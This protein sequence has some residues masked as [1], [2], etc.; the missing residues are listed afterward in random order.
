M[1]KNPFFENYF[2]AI[3]KQSNIFSREEYEEHCRMFEINYG[4]FIPEN[5][6]CKILD[7]GC[8][9]GHFLY[10][11]QKKGYKN[12][13]GIDISEQQSEYCKKNVTE[14]VE[15]VDTFLYLEGKDNSY[16]VITAND[17]I[18]H[19]SKD[20]V[21]SFLSLI[22]KAL[23]PG[24]VCIMKTPNLGNPFTLFLR[25]KDFTH[26]TG[27][28]ETSFYQ[29]FWTSGF[30]DIDILPLRQRGILNN[31]F[32]SVFQ[33]ILR[34]LFWYQGFTAPKILSPLIIGVVKK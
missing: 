7:I 33:F 28:T 4:R 17:L 2:D 20:N 10:F 31:L 18:E 21:I 15:N 5:K 11:L 9:A 8:G 29:V 34:K 6:D 16:D 22:N 27:F 3:F 23:K 14:R 19:I 12:F 13:L 25:Y 26:A 32:C 24:G 30:R 1:D